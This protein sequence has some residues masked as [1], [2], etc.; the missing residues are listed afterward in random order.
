MEAETVKIAAETAAVLAAAKIVPVP[1]P[2]P[3]VVAVTA[4][5]PAPVEKNEYANVEGSKPTAGVN[6]T[7]DNGNSTR[8][9]SLAVP[10]PNRSSPTYPIE[11]VKNSSPVALHTLRC[12]YMYICLYVCT[13]ICIRVCTLFIY[14]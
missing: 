12:V 2:A 7:N 3:V 9:S 11:E 1:P 4:V 14:I 6:T 8:W 13:Y 10:V 5:E